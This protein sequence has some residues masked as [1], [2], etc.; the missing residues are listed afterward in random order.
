MVTT[1]RPKALRPGDVVAIAALANGLDEEEVEL[2]ETGFATVESLGFRVQRSPFTEP[3]RTHW[4]AVA[5]PAEAAAELNRLLHDP[6][7]RGIVALDGGRLA[8]SYLDRVD[9]DAIRADPK[10]IVGSSDISGMLL[11][12]YSRTGLVGIHGDLVRLFAEW[13]D[14]DPDRR[15]Q[16]GEA[17]R[18]VLAGDGAVELPMTDRW[19]C[20][21][22]GRAE[23]R[24]IGG[25][26]NR[27]TRVQASGFAV[28]PERFDGAI[29]FW[30]EAWAQTSVIWQELH[31]LRTAG[32]LDRIAGMVVGAG[33][34]LDFTPGGP[35]N[36]RD[37]VLDVLGDRDI[38]VIGNVEIGHSGPNLPIPLGVRAALDADALTLTLLETAVSG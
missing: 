12:L 5:T 8:L 37:I 28:A 6:E 34:D 33:V 23:G 27:L 17:Y 4:W 19:E 20:W 9:L 16:L 18:R 14:L 13:A 32:A 25:M 15:A 10:P 36:L 2:F 31:G 38:P 30:E 35:D 22:P 7:V 26:L 24:L 21:R 29:L 1:L 3:G 11:A